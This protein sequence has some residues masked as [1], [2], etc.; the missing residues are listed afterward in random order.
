[1]IIIDY[2]TSGEQRYENK[3]IIE[4]LLALPSHIFSDFN[5]C[6]PSDVISDIIPAGKIDIPDPV[7]R[8]G[9]DND[10]NICLWNE[11]QIGAFNKLYSL[12]KYIKKCKN[13]EILKNWQWLQSCNHF[14]YMSSKWFE[15]NKLSGYFCQYDSPYQAYIN[16]MNIL[17]DFSEWVNIY[18]HENCLP[19][20]TSGKKLSRKKLLFIKYDSMMKRSFFSE[21]L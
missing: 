2:E 17:N 18:Y 4:F 7:S 3:G 21:S 13:I 16:Y 5:F 19:K 12:K 8:T 14:F 20:N 15:T 9:R 6:T 10:F 1:M 11:L